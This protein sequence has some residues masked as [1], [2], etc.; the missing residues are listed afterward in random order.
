MENIYQMSGYTLHLIPTKKFKTITISL[1][2][3]SPLLKETTT[4]RTLLTFVLIAATKKYPSTKQLAAYL[5]E[6]YGA[7][8]STH[9]STKGKSQIININTSFVNDK[10]LPTK[11]NLLEKQLQ[12]LNDLF[13]DPYIIQDAFDEVIAQLKKKELKE[14]LQANKDDKFSY[15]LDKLFEYMGRDQVLGIPSTGY[16]NEIQDITASQLY[17]YLLKCIR[18]DVK[19]VYVVGDFQENIVEIFQE[20]LQFP[21]NQQNYLSSYTFESPRAE[22]LEV[23]EK[24][25]ITQSKL[26]LGYTID[27]DFTSKNHYAFT[28]FNALFGGFSQSRLFQVVRE[29]NSLCY[30]ISSSYD[31]FNGV[32]LV[33]AGIEAQDYQKTLNLIEQQLSDL[34]NGHIQ[35]EEIA[36][37]KMMLKNALKKTND[38]ASSMIALAYNRDIT[39]IHETNEEYIEKLMNVTLEEIVQVA[40]NVKLDTIYFL[41]GKEFHENY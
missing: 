4:I 31:A 30:Y 37:A 27:C 8:L 41:T 6:N 15:S 23:I 32:M 20:N 29:Q 40:Q 24:Q 22:V 38:E 19:H 28:V 3:Q 21:Q 33:N 9:V 12:L 18:E 10:F 1:R 36:I 35:D 39:G 13:Y 26:N 16:E 7:S 17:Q 25:D 2:L 5:D 34:K 11:E 14:K